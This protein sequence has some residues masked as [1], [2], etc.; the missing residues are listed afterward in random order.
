VWCACVCVR[1]RV[2]FCSVRG[3]VLRRSVCCLHLSINHSA[4]PPTSLSPPT[5]QHQRY[6]QLVGPEKW[7]ALQSRTISAA[8]HRCQYTG[9][10]SARLPLEAKPILRFA[11]HAR[12]VSVVGL[13]ACA[14]PI[15]R[16]M[17]LDRLTDAE[18][19]KHALGLLMGLNRWDDADLE[20][21]LRGLAM[22]RQRLEAEG[23][24][25]DASELLA[26][27]GAGGGSAAV[28]SRGSSSSTTSKPSSPPPP[29]GL[30][31]DRA[32]LL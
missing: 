16:A 14:A 8:G 22:R 30:L 23:W 4:P 11:P 21:Y 31:D 20:A 27:E 26:R 6:T 9:V 25:F 2:S 18:E 19:R 32:V 15:A 13:T 7:T 24:R 28:I 10:P 17:R 1:M 5:T 29:H 3:W 12:T